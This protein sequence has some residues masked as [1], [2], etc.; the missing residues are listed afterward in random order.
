MNVD[1]AMS[2]YDRNRKAAAKKQHKEMLREEQVQEVEEWKEKTYRS[3]SGVQMH[4]KRA[5]RANANEEV[6]YTGK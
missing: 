3:E 5:Y 6:E 2:S 1:E 4:Y